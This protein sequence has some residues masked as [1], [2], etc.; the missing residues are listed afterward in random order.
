L[1]SEK[2]GRGGW[3]KPRPRGEFRYCFAPG[4]IALHQDCQ[5]LKGVS[6]TGIEPVD[7][8]P[9]WHK[10]FRKIALSA[11]RR[12]RRTPTRTGGNRPL[13][14]ENHRCLAQSPRGHQGRH[15]CSGPSGGFELLARAY[16]RCV[17]FAGVGFRQAAW[18]TVPP[19][20]SAGAGASL[21]RSMLGVE[22]WRFRIMRL[23]RAPLSP[24]RRPAQSA[25]VGLNPR[26]TTH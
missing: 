8:S 19:F 14:R 24:L 13:S 22:S 16:H 15:P 17:T 11:W 4:C 6:P 3:R 26:I 1:S 10:H 2:W 9:L 5:R 20:T 12:I 7:A 23:A 18:P 25:Q 21:A